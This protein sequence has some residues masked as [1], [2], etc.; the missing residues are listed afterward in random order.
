MTTTVRRQC[1]VLQLEDP[2]WTRF[3]TEHPDS[4][5]FHLPAW[6]SAVAQCYGMSAFALA[7]T[8]PDGGVLAGIPVVAVNRPWRARAAKWVA[9]PFTDHCPPLLTDDIDAPT[10]ISMVRAQLA[11][12]A[13][14]HLQ[15][16]D[17]LG[18][19]QAL[20]GVRHVLQLSHDEQAVYRGFHRSQVQRN[21]RRAEREGV[22]VRAATGQSDLT[23]VFYHLHLLTRRRQG[24]PIQPRRFFRLVWSHV[25]APGHGTVLVAEHDGRPLAA[26]VFLRHNGTVIYKYGA[27][28]ADA[29]SLR[30]NH[31]LFWH[32]VRSACAAGDTRFDW[33]RTDLDNEGLRAFKS[34]WGAVEQPLHY[35]TVSAAAGPAPAE[36]DLSG[37]RAARLLATAIQHS[38]PWV[39]S[40]VGEALYRF[41]A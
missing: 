24:V 7:A 4:T 26:A 23:D 25:I 39:C 41:T 40:A 5:V 31:A 12:S 36:R 1:E 3:I 6:V 15:I 11:S 22:T 8:A 2:R 37:S 21:I 18:A 35:T 9:L 16:R 38:P 10:W 27:S 34:A 29:W 32:A 30:P 20:V 28:D 14:P 19:E 13:V 17:G 33:G